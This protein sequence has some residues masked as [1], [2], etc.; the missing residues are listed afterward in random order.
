MN[1][2]IVTIKTLLSYLKKNDIKKI[3][4][5]FDR[6][7]IVDLAHLMNQLTEAKD[8]V[9]IF[10]T[11]NSDHT[12]ELFT[13]LS[14]EQQANLIH[15]F[16][17]KQLLKLLTSSF[18]DDIADFLE[19]MPANLVSRIL[20]VADAELR[21]DINLL[22]NY[23]PGTAGSIMTTEYLTIPET[24]T[25]NQTLDRIRKIGKNKETI[26]SNFIIDE[27]RFLKGVIYI[28]DIVYHEGEAKVIDIMNQDFISC[29]VTTDQEEVAQ[30]FKRYDLSVIPVLN[31]SQ[32]LVGII[33]IDDVVDVIEKVASEDIFKMAAINPLD[34]SYRASSP[35]DITKKSLPWILGLMV[36]GA[37]STVTINQFESTFQRVIILTA[38]I[39]MIMN[40]GGNAGN[41]SIAI[42][43]RALATKEITIDDT[44][45]IIKK[46][47]LTALM[48]GSMTA[49]F[50]FFWIIILLVSGIVRFSTS[51]A[52]LSWPW[53]IETMRISGLVA[54]TLFIAVFFAKI[55][56]SFLPLIATKIKKDPAIMS[57]P[58][59]TT[60]M[61]FSSLLIYFLLANFLFNFF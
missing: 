5:L 30:L 32:H 43:T 37:V 27:K 46:E 19:D 60:I 16:T 36:I 49:L 4:K 8:L 21:Q 23:K 51:I 31:E 40:T 9:Y 54:L 10:R 20:K 45:L 11:C 28:E 33:T 13:Y 34:D 7:P 6:F 61:D 14:S 26:N 44:K 47:L 35:L 41:Q 24:F 39:P 2:K 22:L 56:G 53:F 17:D 55:L 59:L 58:F 18:T 52:S 15:S 29:F 42:V 12:A 48:M 25:I 1:Q 57:S 3:R 50:S 38:F